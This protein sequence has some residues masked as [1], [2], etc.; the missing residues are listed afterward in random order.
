MFA[1]NLARSI[2]QAHAAGL[3]DI[4]TVIWKAWSAHQIADDDAQRLAEAVEARRAVLAACSTQRPTQRP[5][6]LEPRQIKAA[7]LRRRRL[8]ASGPMPPTMADR[9]RPSELAV[10]RIVADEVRQHGQCDRTLGEI[11]ARSG[12]CRT[13]V[14][15]AVR[16]A[17]RLGLLRVEERRRPGRPNLPNRVAIVSRE[18][19]AWIARGPRVEGSRRSTPRIV[20]IQDRPNTS[21]KSLM[22]KGVFELTGA[23]PVNTEATSNPEPRHPIPPDH[24]GDRSQRRR[25]GPA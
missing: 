21:R 5:R 15:N 11:A 16:E 3:A 18:W 25:E 8:A 1:D 4:N 14:Q 12:T 9:F 19:L 24:R 2:E 17:A 7:V 23:A 22:N 13:S 10:L 20:G 6:R